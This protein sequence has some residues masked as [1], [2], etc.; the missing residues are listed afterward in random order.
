M[1][2]NLKL[3][4]VAIVLCLGAV[5]LPGGSA[6]AQELGSL[7]YYPIT[8]AE[9]RDN[10]YAWRVFLEYELNR[11]PCQRYQ[12]PPAGFVMRGCNLYRVESAIQQT[13]SVVDQRT[14]TKTVT[15]LESAFT[16]YFDFDKS[17]IREDGM[18]MIE[19]AAHD[20]E[21]F[22]PSEVGISGYAARSG[23]ADYNQELSERRAQSITNELVRLGVDRDIIRQS[24]YGET[25]LAVQTD[26]GVRMP[27]NRR[28]IISFKR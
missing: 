21:N 27:A 24:A 11:E 2:K 20:I 14:V 15:P 6:R 10:H 1:K 18:R 25:H 12:A 8:E 5:A 13:T 16:I 4:V 17:N 28:A 19:K 23:A 22:N 9:Y 7:A 26:D 3:S